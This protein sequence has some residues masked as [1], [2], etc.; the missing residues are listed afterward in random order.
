LIVTIE[1]L[2]SAS[3]TALEKAREQRE[4]PAVEISEKTPRA[5]QQTKPHRRKAGLVLVSAVILSAMGYFSW[6]HFRSAAVPKTGKIMLAVLPF[7]NLTGD[8]N[9]EYL[10]DALT[11]ETIS[12]L[13]RLNRSSWA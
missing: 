1:Y 8:P 3:A 7:E 13:G 11:E 10:A 4:Q 9:K 2:E 12:Q 5:R 6:R